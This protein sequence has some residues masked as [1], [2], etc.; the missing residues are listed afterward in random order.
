MPQNLAGYRSLCLVTGSAEYSAPQV[1]GECGL[2]LSSAQGLVQLTVTV[3]VTAPGSPVPPVA[4][5][6][7]RYTPGLMTLPLMLTV[8]FGHVQGLGFTAKLGLIASAGMFT[9]IH[10]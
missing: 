4:W 8:V 2:V 10:A 3:V 5:N 1:T 7:T 6:S 9:S